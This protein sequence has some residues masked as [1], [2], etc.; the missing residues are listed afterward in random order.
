MKRELALASGSWK[1]CVSTTGLAGFMA[2]ELS[3]CPVLLSWHSE[4]AAAPRSPSFPA[5]SHR[6]ASRESSLLS[7]RPLPVWKPLA[8]CALPGGCGGAG[9]AKQSLYGKAAPRKPGLP[10]SDPGD[11]GLGMQGW[12]QQVSG[13]T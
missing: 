9:V 10:K 3:A 7:L 6:P 13:T 1:R 4:V 12:A 2:S 5:C 8:H 11:L